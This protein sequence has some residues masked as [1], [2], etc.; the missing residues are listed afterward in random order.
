VLSDL[1]YRFRALFRRKLMEA[2]MEE[3]LRAHLEHQT[4]MYINS[5]LPP[6]EAQRRARLDLGGVE[7][8]KEECRDAG[9]VRFIEELIQDIRYGLRQLQRNPGFTAV[10]I[11]TLALGIGATT[12][13]FT[14]ENGLF[15]H[16][17]GVPDA[18]QVV[19]LRVRYD[20][21][22]LKSLVVS[23]P[24]FVHIQQRKDLFSSAAIEDPWASDFNYSSG[25]WPQH[26]V[27]AMVTWQW[28][29]VFRARPL[30]GRTFTK[31][32]DQP[33]ANYE[34]VL[35]YHAWKRW[36]GGDPGIVGRSIRLND[37]Y[38]RVIGV[39][40]Q[41]FDWPNEVALWTPLGL[42]PAEFAIDRTFSEEYFAV[43]RLAPKVSFARA[44]AAVALMERR[45]I[46]DPTTSYARGSGWGM[47]ILPVTRFVYG[48]LRKPLSILAGAVGF[49]LLIACANIAGL[50]LARAAGRAREF[51]LRAALGASRRR[52][53]RQMLAE[54][55]L[56]AIAGGLVGA[57][58]A[59]LGIRALTA[60]APEN[61][62]PEAAFP[63]DGRVLLFA[64]GAVILA[65]I[66]AGTIPAWAAAQADA[67]SVLKEGSRSASSGRSRGKLRSALVVGELALGLVLLTGTGLL[68]G[69]L[70]KLSRVNPGFQ[71]QDVI[72]AAV[73][74][75]QVKYNTPQKR[76]TFFRSV[77][78][79]LSATPGVTAAG[80]GFPMPFSGS[81]VTGSFEIEGRPGAPGSPGPWGGM[82]YVTP[83]FFKALGIRLLQGRT[84]SDGDRIDTQRLAVIDE[85]LARRYWPNRDPVGLKIRRGDN[86]PWATI[87]GVVGNVRFGQMA[88]EEQS[89]EGV[90]SGHR[91]VVYFSMY[92][93][94][95]PVVFFLARTIGDPMALG[96][97]IRRAVRDVDA[98]QP[99]YDLRSMR[100]L[101]WASMGPQRF[102][103][104]LLG[105]FAAIA[106]VLASVGLYGVISYGVAQRRHEFGIRM[107][108]GARKHDVLGLVLR[109]GMTL[110]LL[111]VG[112]G[113]AVAL[114]LTRF[115]SSLLYGVKATD[116]LTFIAV[117]LIL[118]G[119]ALLASYI[120]ARRAIKVDPMVAL[121][122][123]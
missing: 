20:K 43:A 101:V 26:L 105:V 45:V 115:W 33:G 123:E 74:L 67:Y 91:G 12:A 60:V 110:A 68:L 9:G 39:M 112:T 35:A 96:G 40:R 89:W 46:D 119:V 21:F 27:G 16:P 52:L 113:I 90:Q 29:R 14:V 116:P 61:L 93:V 99:V 98:N 2:D 24:D 103:L 15:L 72:T 19:V 97:A 5:G 31:Q 83:G 7:Q 120:P 23:A 57:V 88:G 36:F 53:V 106:L 55:L 8:V 107:A 51:A 42:K 30:L 114:V 94:P 1:V 4:E 65:A 48:D 121:R 71:P 18:A 37:Q 118:T 34:V 69:S 104:T 17:A 64:L 59:K 6:E 50:L 86:D 10:A 22:G 11:I 70:S 32:E 62:M 85:S 66:V 108:L 41:G 95:R 28:F 102:S 80:A 47:F 92:Q 63:M 81:N 111:G 100:Q 76:V 122:Y 54:T 78:D 84:F 58:L 109:Q 25:E 73:A 82:R 87:V 56:I 79:R 117:S 3:Q 75:P 44:S 38:Y 13:I 77:V 49:V